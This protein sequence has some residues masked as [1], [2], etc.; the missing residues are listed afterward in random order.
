MN[1]DHQPRAKPDQHTAHAFPLWDPHRS[2][3]GLEFQSGETTETDRVTCKTCLQ[4]ID[5]IKTTS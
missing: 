3:C 4:E 2:F 5:R 1:T